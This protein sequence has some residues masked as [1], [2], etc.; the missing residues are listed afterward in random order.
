MEPRRKTSEVREFII[1]N[2]RDHPRD[3]SRLTAEH[4]GIS[5]TAVIKHLHKL[6]E[7][8]LL[9]AEGSTK[10]RSYR[11]KNLV[12]K[13]LPFFPVDANLQEDIVWRE[14]I[15]PQLGDLTENVR[16]IC[17]FGFTE[18]FNNVIDHSGSKTVQVGVRR[19]AA[20]IGLRVW[21]RGIGIF[22]KLQ[23][24]FHLNDQIGRAHV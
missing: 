17:H 11:L 19:D 16:A 20:F 14:R 5:R 4:F 7:E 9:E 24:D 22:N 2:L 1:K 23:A 12:C 15:V 21:D 18:M 8:G 10:D 3:I 13:M 6:L